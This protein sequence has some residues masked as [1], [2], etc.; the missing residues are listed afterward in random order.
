MAGGLIAL[1]LGL[2]LLAGVRA[3]T[4]YATFVL[5]LLL[6]GTGLAFP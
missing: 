3:D 5:P 6:V 1:V 2:V 4:P